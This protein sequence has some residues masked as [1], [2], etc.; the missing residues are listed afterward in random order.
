MAVSA[1]SLKL[2]PATPAGVTMLGVPLSVMPMNATFTV[3]PSLVK[4][5]MPVAG[6]SVVPSVFTVLAARKPKLAPGKALFTRQGSSGVFLAQPPFFMR[7]SSVWPLSNSWLPTA[8]KSIFI[9]FT[10][11]MVGSSRN[12]A[13]TS[14]EA[15]IMSPAETTAL[16]SFFALSDAMAEAR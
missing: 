11:S 14:G 3:A 15:P 9:A 1:S 10:A 2:R 13:D 12:S 5:L 4:L 6:N 8:L 16:F 7:R